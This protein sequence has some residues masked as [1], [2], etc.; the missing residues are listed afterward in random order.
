MSIPQDNIYNCWCNAKIEAMMAEHGSTGGI[1]HTVVKGTVRE[2]LVRELIQQFLPAPLAITS[3]SIF[4]LF[5]RMSRFC[6]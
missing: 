5:P 1:G 2:N 6:F 4:S 3:G